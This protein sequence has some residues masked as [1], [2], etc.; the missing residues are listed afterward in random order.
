MDSNGDRFDA[1]VIPDQTACLANN[2][3][4][5]NSRFNF[6]HVGQSYLSLFQVAIFKGWTGVLYDALDSRE[7]K[8]FLKKMHSA[9]FLSFFCF[10]STSLSFTTLPGRNAVLGWGQKSTFFNVWIRIKKY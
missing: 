2:H 7:V 3:S 8:L 10:Y 6:D 5:V 1:E 9:F 4:W